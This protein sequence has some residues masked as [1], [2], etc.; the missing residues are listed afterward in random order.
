MDGRPVPRTGKG[1]AACRHLPADLPLH[2]WP[3]DAE[4]ARDLARVTGHRRWS[5]DVSRVACPVRGRAIAAAY[6]AAPDVD[7]WARPAYRAF[8]SETA[9]QF[10]VLTA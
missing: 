5:V 9:R 8:R 2:Q 1:T 6:L 3:H 10:E 7:V 4:L